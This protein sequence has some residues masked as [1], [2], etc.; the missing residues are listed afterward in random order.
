MSSP[1]QLFRIEKLD[2][3]LDVLI[4]PDAQ[5]RTVAAGFSFSDGPVW[6]RGR[7][8]AEGYLLAVSI[9]DN[10]IYKVTAAGRV[11]VFLDHA[12]YSGDDVANVGK[13]AL[14]G[15][16]HVILVGPNCTGV[17]RQGR[18]IWCAGQDLALMRLEKD[19]TRTVLAKGFEGKHFNG[20]NDVA[21]ARDGSIYFTDSDVGL[22]GGIHSPLVQMPDSVW[23]WKDGEVVQ[24]VSREQLGAE[25]NGIALSPD[26][27]YLYLSAGTG[28]A[29]PKMMRY[30]IHADGSIGPGE[31]FSHGRGI[32]DG[33][34]A[35]RFGNIYSTDG[36][37][38]IVRITS[39]AGQP[40]GLLHLPTPGDIEPRKTTC[41]SA[42]AFG[43]DDGRTLYVTACEYIYAIALRTPGI[44]E[45]PD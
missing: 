42:L 14:I 26:D 3:S 10:V 33:M 23:R 29:D 13:L 12:G 15:R 45:G 35:D 34:K 1:A 18:V 30:P 40:L 25:P 27:R 31:V 41:A 22:R 43:G 28:S 21:I 8:G 7:D 9:I 5:V 32:G 6:I 39:P 38:P 11:S 24:A 2:P 16:T 17:D 36:P 37:R 44:L 20:P 19:G 4:A